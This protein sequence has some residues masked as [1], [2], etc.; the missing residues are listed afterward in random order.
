MI[1]SMSTRMN[2]TVALSSLVILL[3]SCVAA[4]AGPVPALNLR[5]LVNDS[6]LIVVGQVTAVLERERTSID[7]GGQP[8]AATR[9]AATLRPDRTLK[10]QANESMIYLEF[11]LSD[12]GSFKPIQARQFGIF[13][14][15]KRPQGFAVTSPYYPFLVAG[16]RQP[17]SAGDVLERVV[18]EFAGVIRLSSMRRA[19][20]TEAIEV[21]SHVRSDVASEALRHAVADPD[22]SIRIRANAALLWQNDISAMS[23]AVDLLLNPPPGAEQYLLERLAASI[24]GVKDPRA[25]ASLNRLKGARQSSVRRATAA[26]L[27]GTGTE[28]TIQPLLSLLN[29]RDQGV[30]YQAV[31]GLAE[32]TGQNDW[33]PAIDL[34]QRD[35]QTYLEHWRSWGK[36][37]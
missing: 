6:D 27:R 36:T 29:D 28:A 30:R 14:L 25:I 3:L 20:R 19:A 18:A 24:E 8:T 10:G 33:A 17:A 1:D 35:E 12:F 23:G 34:F 16:R 13:F 26:A 5:E 37:R 2:K 32:I 9:M 22:L 7:V 21:L 11:V 4:E 15:K 31:L